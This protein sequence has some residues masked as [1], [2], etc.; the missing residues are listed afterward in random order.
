MASFL[1]TGAGRG[2]GLALTQE[3]ASRPASEV[4]VIVASTRKPSADL[5]AVGK[6]SGGRVAIVHFDV[7]DEASIKKAVPE[8]EKVLGGKGLDVLVNN[9]GIAQYAPDGVKSM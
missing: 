7:V 8:V 2:F 5:D 1:I 6:S 3:L 9:A 4:S